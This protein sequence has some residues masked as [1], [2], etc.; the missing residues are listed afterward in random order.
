[1][2]PFN[3]PVWLGTEASRI[4]EAIV[5]N[6][7]V[8]SGGPFGVRCEAMLCRQL[9]QPTLLTSSCTHA[10][11]MAALLLDIGPGDEVILPSFAFVSTANAFALRGAELSF[12]DVG[13]DGNIDPNRVAE[14]LTPRT[15]AVVAVHY[16]GNS[17]DLPQLLAACGK[18]PLIEDAAQAIG[19]SFADR[20]LGTWGTLGAFS[21]HETKNIGCGEGGAL[22]LRDPAMHRERAHMI[23]DKGTNRQSFIAGEVSKYTWTSLGSSYGL[24]DLNAAYLLSQLEAFET[25]QTRRRALYTAYLEAL[26]APLERA[27]GYLVRAH[28]GNTPNHHLFAMVLRDGEQRDAFIAHM[29]SHDIVTPFHYVA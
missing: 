2:I 19:A 6:G 23:R 21:F 24:S 4:S 5:E 12:V 26:S 17:C 18:V 9:G 20:P 25:I 11:E 16:A 3:K 1:M 22:T 28:P 15:R 7:H 8:A 13:Q 29:K 14:A 27:G 10:L